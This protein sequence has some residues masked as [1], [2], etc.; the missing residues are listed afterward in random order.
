MQLLPK[1]KTK[2]QSNTFYLI[3]SIIVIIY[4][5]IKTYV[6][7]YESKLINNTSLVGTITNLVREDEHLRFTLKV[8]DELV[9]CDYYG[10]LANSYILGKKVK[11]EGTSKE[12]R[13]NTIPNT[14]NYKK[15]LYHN[16]IYLAYNVNKID[17]LEG[18]NIFYKGKN[19][20]IKKIDKFDELS[21]SY[22][23]LFLLGDKNYL[24]DEVYNTYLK[25][26]VV[27]LFAISGMH[28]SLLVSI[29]NYLLKKIKGKKIIIGLFLVYFAFL[30]NFSAS[31]MRAVT[32]Y[33]M[34][35][36]FKLLNITL[37]NVKILLLTAFLLLFINPFFI[38]N[39]GFLYSFL[40][41]F[42]I[43]LLSKDITGN[44]VKKIF[45]ISLI[46]FLVS[47]P[48][49]VSNNYEIN[50]LSIFSNLLFVPLV[51][52]VIF[53][54]SLIVFLIPFL[55]PLFHLC[56]S[57]L[58]C[59]NNIIYH[60]KLIIIIP[61]MSLILIIL[62]YLVLILMYK[63]KNSK[64]IFLIGFILI[65]NGEI[66]KLDSSFYAYYIDVSQG[67][68]AVLISPYQR[69]V[70]MI[71]T[72]GIVGSDYHVVSN[73][74]TFLKS[75]GIKKI[76]KLIITHGDY[77]HMGDATYLINHFKV[78]EVYLN[79]PSN[80]LLEEDLLNLL[81]K[82]KIPEY[83]DVKTILLPN[84][85]INFLKTL[86]YDNENDNSN[87]LYFQY[88]NYN[89]LFMGDASTKVEE[90]LLK[91][92]KL[93]VIDFLKVG[94]HGSKTSSSDLFIN[95]IKP[96]YSII[97]VGKNNR[98]GH[99]N[100]EVLNILAKSQILRT[101]MDGSIRLKIKGYNLEIDKYP[102]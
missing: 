1:L 91:K 69:D 15:Y 64:L 7:K 18:E 52:L 83:S 35:N 101:D 95:S 68:S 34:K 49:T 102:P 26:G 2:L 14:F 16:K 82:K 60:W 46:A 50:I 80:N 85:H 6:I 84:Y 54:F 42:S 24:D 40:I 58:E 87:I 66:P 4:I 97:S 5:F 90:N 48:L 88:H 76:D 32:F 79:T 96:K 61:K 67:D 62:Y 22:L 33:I 44:Y 17:V 98:Y 65:I 41:T 57:I 56:L 3:L 47:L 74:I 39:Q 72:G 63:R 23:S 11:I 86:D 29:L 43:M 38:Y 71:D 89:F 37:S 8:Q 53:P 81:N 28:I 51:S 21:K 10:E 73:T 12:V 77:D 100:E 70:I 25:N 9:I 55:Q 27:H 19:Y 94:H 45:K 59:L 36:I 30:T 20:I 99:P 92:Y 93:P 75:L 31:V 13:N 78:K